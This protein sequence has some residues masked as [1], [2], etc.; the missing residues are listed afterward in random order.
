MRNIITGYKMEYDEN[1]KLYNILF[2]YKYPFYGNQ[3][4]IDEEFINDPENIFSKILHLACIEELKN[5]YRVVEWLEKNANYCPEWISD[6]HLSMS[7][8]IFDFSE[9]NIILTEKDLPI[10]LSHPLLPNS[11]DFL[12]LENDLIPNK[13]NN[14]WGFIGYRLYTNEYL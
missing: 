2:G 14:P 8:K 5:S 3:G 6:L 9:W 4:I 13:A 7:N 11:S 1:N 12:E 10:L